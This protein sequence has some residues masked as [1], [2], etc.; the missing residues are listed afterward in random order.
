MQIRKQVLTFLS[1]NKKENFIWC[2]KTQGKESM[3]KWVLWEGREQA[4]QSKRGT[5]KDLKL[6]KTSV[7]GF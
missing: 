1:K 3:V 4:D 5:Y 6:P 2:Q 7:Q